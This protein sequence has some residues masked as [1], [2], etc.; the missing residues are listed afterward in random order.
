MAS[1]EHDPQPAIGFAGLTTLVSNVDT[2]LL[3]AQEASSTPPIHPTLPLYQSETAQPTTNPSLH[4]PASSF[5]SASNIRLLIGIAVVIGIVWIFYTNLENSKNYSFS[6]NTPAPVRPAE[7]TMSPRMPSVQVP[8]NRPSETVPPIG[9]T[10]ILGPAQIRY[11]VAEHI[12]LDNAS[13]VVDT[14]LRT[15][16]EKFNKMV[17]DFNS[18]CSEYRAH[19]NDVESAKADLEPF[20]A[21]LVDEG[22]RRFPRTASRKRQDVFSVPEEPLGTGESPDDISS[23]TAD[24]ADG[25]TTAHSTEGR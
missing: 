15:H 18:R 25:S 11:C 7:P 5:V 4:T 13:N 12:R 2:L 1:V 3:R 17:S 10:H 9:T 24:T 8:I 16:V 21:I 22:R 20:R 14:H 19:D 6:H 23:E